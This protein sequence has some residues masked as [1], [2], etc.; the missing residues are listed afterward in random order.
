VHPQE[1]NS[2][3]FPC[4][5]YHMEGNIFMEEKMDTR[6]EKKGDVFYLK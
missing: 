4:A 6:R 3:F 1:S 5:V 2:E